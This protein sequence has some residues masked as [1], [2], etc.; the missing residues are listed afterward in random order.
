MLDA[1]VG[2]SIIDFNDSFTYNISSELYGQNI[3]HKVVELSKAAGFL[4]DLNYLLTN[5]SQTKHVVIYGP[6]PGHPQDYSTLFPMIEALFARKN[7]LHFGVCLGHQIIWQI[8][9][10]NAIRSKKPIHG[11]QVNVTIPP[12]KGI[13]PKQFWGKEVLVSRYN[14]LVVDSVALEKFPSWKFVYTDGEC[15]MSTGTG[16]ITYQFHPESVG[17]S[18]PSMFFTPISNFFV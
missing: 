4:Q 13:F 15:M 18:C 11:Q 16:I 10:V 17:T 1:T 6:G 3:N 2:V 5:N 8:K 9:G 12:W 7:L 14:S